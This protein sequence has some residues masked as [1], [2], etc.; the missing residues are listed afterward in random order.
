M[1]I[2]EGARSVGG[3]LAGGQISTQFGSKVWGAFWAGQ[4]CWGLISTHFGSKFGGDVVGVDWLGGGLALTLEV[5]LGEAFWGVG[6]VGGELAGGQTVTH[7]GSEIGVGR[8][9][10]G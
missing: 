2:L 7:F 3:E 4:I 5:N 10:G 8:G 1:G 6:S 9:R